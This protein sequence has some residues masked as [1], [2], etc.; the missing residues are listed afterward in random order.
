MKKYPPIV[1]VEVLDRAIIVLKRKHGCLTAYPSM[2]QGGTWILRGKTYL[3]RK[4]VVSYFNP[5]GSDAGEM[6]IREYHFET[7]AEMFCFVCKLVAR[8]T[9]EQWSERKKNEVH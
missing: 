8:L 7:L 6:V 2:S 4:L 5:I 9:R 1:E 3:S